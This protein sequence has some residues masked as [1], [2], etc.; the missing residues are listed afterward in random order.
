MSSNTTP[1]G[2]REITL[3][4]DSK[5]VEVTSYVS[6]EPVRFQRL[7]GSVIVPEAPSARRDT[8]CAARPRRVLPRRR[9]AGRPRAQAARSSAKS[10]DSGDDS[11]DSEPPA[12]IELW[13]WAD[14]ASWRDFLAAR[15]SSDGAMS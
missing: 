7:D 4:G 2:L 5:P 3:D 11:G 15:Q 1:S 6:D 9:G 14:P 13:R 12:A 10:G 8:R